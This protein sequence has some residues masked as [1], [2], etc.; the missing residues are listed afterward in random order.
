MVI[1]DENNGRIG[2]LFLR[3]DGSDKDECLC[4][5]IALIAYITELVIAHAELSRCQ[6]A[7]SPLGSAVELGFLIIFEISIDLIDLAF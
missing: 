1:A 3:R 7:R 5:H 4:M 2:A 6:R